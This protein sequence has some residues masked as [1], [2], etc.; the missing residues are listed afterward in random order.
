MNLDHGSRFV[1]ALMHARLR[2]CEKKL[3]ADGKPNVATREWAGKVLH[4][5]W[6]SQLWPLRG[7]RHGS[8]LRYDDVTG[9]PKGMTQSYFDQATAE[10]KCFGWAVVRKEGQENSLALTL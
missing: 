8:G 10:N 6:F 4:S 2:E 7:R 9:L 1:S 5:G 3:G